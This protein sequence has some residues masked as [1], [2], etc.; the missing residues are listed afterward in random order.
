MRRIFLIFSVTAALAFGCDESGDTQKSVGNGKLFLLFEECDIEASGAVESK[1][2]CAAQNLSVRA[3]NPSAYHLCLAAMEQNERLKMKFEAT[4]TGVILRAVC[5]SDG[6]GTSHRWEAASVEEYVDCTGSNHCKSGWNDSFWAFYY[7]NE[8][9]KA[10]FSTVGLGSY[11]LKENEEIV[12][13]FSK[14]RAEQIQ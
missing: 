8:E 1:A 14:Y 5:L 3:K 7:L 12:L 13:M 2:I 11:P 10:V 4:G 6:N 9:K